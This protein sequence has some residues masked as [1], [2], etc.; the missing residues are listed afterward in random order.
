M[1]IKHLGTDSSTAK[2]LEILDRDAGVIIDN[3]LSEDQIKNINSDLEPYLQN[4]REG[5]D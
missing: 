4:T 3:V 2:I 1:G 5:Q